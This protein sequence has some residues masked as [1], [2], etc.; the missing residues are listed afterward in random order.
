MR[1][2]RG[3]QKTQKGQEDGPLLSLSLGEAGYVMHLDGA[4]SPV[5]ARRKVVRWVSGPG[6]Q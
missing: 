4:S 6:G 3:E 1:E 2:D 5:E